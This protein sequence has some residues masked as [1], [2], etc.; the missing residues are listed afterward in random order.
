MGGVSGSR[1]VISQSS[2]QLPTIEAAPKRTFS[3]GT[4]FDNYPPQGSSAVPGP[5]LDR[6]PSWRGSCWNQW[7]QIMEVL[8]EYISW[9]KRCSCLPPW[10]FPGSPGSGFSSSQRGTWLR[11][12]PSTSSLISC[13]SKYQTSERFLFHWGSFLSEEV[14][15]NSRVRIFDLHVS[16]SCHPTLELSDHELPHDIH[17]G[18]NSGISLPPW[19]LMMD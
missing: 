9:R 1:S 17:G 12:C 15:V 7:F 8:R 16:F 6:K 10:P 13:T 5:G 14:Q 3:C 19:T 11:P 2:S 18:G 4:L